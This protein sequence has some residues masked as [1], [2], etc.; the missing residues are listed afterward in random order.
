MIAGV[1]GLAPLRG[2]RNLPRGDLDAL[3]RAV[4]A[5]SN[6]ALVGGT[7]VLEA[8]I[9]PLMVRAEGKGAVAVDGLVVLGGQGFSGSQAM[10]CS[11]FPSG[12]NTG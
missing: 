5:V 7:T 10:T 3:A 11:A 6:L 2:Y 4:V 8:E 1:K 12:G 9:N